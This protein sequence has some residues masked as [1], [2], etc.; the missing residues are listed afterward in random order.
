MTNPL[1]ENG[2]LPPFSRIQP[3][4]MEPALTGVLA[5]NRQAI[6][7]LLRARIRPAWDTLVGPLE[8][9]DDRIDHV[10]SPIRH[11]NSVLD[12]PETR[13][14]HDRC[15]AA[16]T[17]YYTA[18][19]QN[20]DLYDALRR[21][22]EAGEALDAAQRKL[23][24]DQ[25]REFELG[26]VA[27]PA[28]PKQRFK[29]IQQELSELSST[30]EKNLLDGT[31]AWS[32]PLETDAE[33]AGLPESALD[34]ARQAARDAGS[35]GYLLTLQHPSY[36]A[37]MTYAADR[38]L[39]REVYT[40]YQTRA[41]DQGPHAGHRD[42]T[43]IIERIMSLRHEAARL[44]DY[45]NYAELSLATKMADSPDQVTDFLRDMA[46]KALPR[47]RE[48][49]AELQDYAAADLSGEPLMP[50]DVAYYSEKLRNE[51]YA[52]SQEAI[53]PWFPANRVLNGLFDI[54]G[55]LF[56]I[57]VTALDTDEVWH[58]DVRLYEIRDVDNNLR[59]RFFLDLYAR[60]NKRGGAW[61]DECYSR[62]RHRKG[63][64]H[65][66]A[67]LTCNLTPPVDGRPAL[68]THDDVLTL[69]H[70]FGHGLHH[71][72]TTVDYPEIAG[73]RGVEWDAVELP[74]QF[75]ENWCWDPAALRRISSHH[76]TG[77]PLPD[78]MIEKLQRARNFHS[79]MHMVRQLEFS[80]YDMRLHAEYDP[81]RGARHQTLLDEVRREVAVIQPPEFVRFQHG[82]SHIFAGGYAAGYYS[83]LWAEVLSADAFSLFE[84]NGVFDPAT[85]RR[86][87][88]EILER[89]GSRNAMASFEAFRG[90]APSADALLRHCG[91]NE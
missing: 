70:E 64:Q 38:A 75:L 47:A 54:V 35:D 60:R 74:S 76:K 24:D 59:G 23:L 67:F 53:K 3:G 2:E 29:A 62:F 26:G 78:S 19:A 18:L 43:P 8:E 63:L 6:D 7:A 50:W 48:E 32:R 80:L 88:S 40:A 34:M 9:L 5:E 55:S 16:V 49:F 66:A 22:A 13:A 39:R 28:G 57:R 14:A 77:E 79:A 4:H 73:I 90:R 52:V 56:G 20:A 25:L 81:A 69:F 84:E 42:N 68:L 15:L 58:P 46:A 31:L 12:T 37:A 61:M 36:V 91:L 45:K 51:R 21:L 65:P 1:L 72:L 30:F 89:G 10:W 82:F 86:F 17:D 44:L 33:R 83:Y 71:M 27:L 85:G 41:S 87:L 11:L